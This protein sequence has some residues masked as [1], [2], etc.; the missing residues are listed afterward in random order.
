MGCLCDLPWRTNL[1][2][3]A[4]QPIELTIAPFEYAFPVDAALKALKFRR[5][6]DY[7]AA[8]AEI[9]WR[10]SP[11]LPNDVDAL[12]PVPLHWR[13]HTMRGFNQA[14]ELSLWL[15]EKS[16]LP[17]LTNFVRTRRTSFQSGL[18]AAERRRNLRHA[19]AVHGSC[20]AQ[21]VLIVDDVITTGAT[22][23]E[24][25]RRAIAAGAKKVSVLAVARSS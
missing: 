19:F 21:H 5:R 17:L 15:S 24:L 25:A 18:A 6:L 2:S 22:S 11:A 4:E 13:R 14:T 9:L 1:V 20:S 23:S 10:V 16:G 7:V 8:F 12:L 3:E